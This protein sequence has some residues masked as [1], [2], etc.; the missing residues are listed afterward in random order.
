MLDNPA[1]NERAQQLLK[2]LIERYISNGRPVSSKE[3]SMNYSPA[4]IR[5][6]MADLEACGYICSPHTSAGRVPTALGYR[7]F[8]DSLLTVKPLDQQAVQQVQEQLNAQ[9]DVKTVS[10]LLSGITQ[11]VGLVTLPRHERLQLRQV[12]FLPLSEKRILVILVLNGQEVQNRVIHTERVYT[13]NELQQAANYLNTEY[14]GKDLMDVRRHLLKALQNDQ[15]QMNRLMQAAIEIADKAFDEPEDCVVAGQT[16]VFDFAGVDKLRELFD[17]FTEKQAILHLLDQCIHTEG[18]Q[19]Y[20][21]NEAGYDIFND[22]T[23]I[24]APYTVGD[25]VVGALGVI[26]PTRMA[27]DR[28]IP[29]VDITAKLFSA[30]L[31]G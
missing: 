28:V 25:K 24:T 7:Y 6:I 26:G 11:L 18:I 8:V 14:A 19:I 1:V 4:T 27:Y 5:N 9:S 12:E 29:M 21:G 23:M 15:Q 17:A 13:A 16:R 22:C 30:A 2:V 20:I 10:S 31:S 3:L